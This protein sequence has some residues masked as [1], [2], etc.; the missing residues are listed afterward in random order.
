MLDKRE[1]TLDTGVVR[2]HL[3]DRIVNVEHS[4]DSGAGNLFYDRHCFGERL[5]DVGLTDGEGFHQEA[6]AA[7]FA[8]RRRDTESGN[9]MSRG[10]FAGEAAG[11]LALIRGPKH[12]HA[13]RSE[14]GA[15]VD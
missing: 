10:L 14:I 12:Q 8:V 5:Y 6:H 11:A 7:I 2:L 1:V 3:V 15:K 9:E 4:A 13:A